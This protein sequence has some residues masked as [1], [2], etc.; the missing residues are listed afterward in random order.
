MGSVYF[1]PYEHIVSRMRLVACNRR[2]LLDWR[3]VVSAIGIVAGYKKSSWQSKPV[4]YF[5]IEISFLRVYL[6]H[7][8]TYNRVIE[9]LFTWYKYFTAIFCWKPVWKFSNC[10]IHSLSPYSCNK[11]LA[12]CACTEK[13]IEWKSKSKVQDRCAVERKNVTAH[14]FGDG[15]YRCSAF[16]WRLN[17]LICLF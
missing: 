14:F 12:W 7:I 4:T 15:I 5:G 11:S 16:T 17:N 8:I 3:H 2:K 1:C 6:S 13:I 10:K 9:Y